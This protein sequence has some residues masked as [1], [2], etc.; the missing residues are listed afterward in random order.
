[1]WD[2]HQRSAVRNSFSCWPPPCRGRSPPGPSSRRPFVPRLHNQFPDPFI[3]PARRRI[4]R[5]RH[6]C[7]S[8]S[9]RMCRWPGSHRPGALAAGPR[10]RAAAR[11]ACRCCRPGRG[12]A[13]PGRPKC[14]GTASAICSISPPRSGGAASQCVGVAEL[15]RAAGPF[16]G[17]HRAAGLPARARRDDRSQ[18]FPRRRRPALSLLQE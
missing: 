2:S 13:G 6:Q 9:A 11:R 1:M 17:S 12:R 18:R 3:L 14:F 5:L 7:G 15:G 16:T 10:R 8:A 4:P